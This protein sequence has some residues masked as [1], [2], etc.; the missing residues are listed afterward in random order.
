MAADGW[1]TGAILQVERFYAEGQDGA[2]R[3]TQ[4]AIDTALEEGRFT[5]EDL[6]DAGRAAERYRGRRNGGDQQ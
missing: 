4:W 5:E 1:L 6:L 2:A 3:G